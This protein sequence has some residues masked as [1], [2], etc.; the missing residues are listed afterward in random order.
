MDYLCQTADLSFIESED[1]LDLRFDTLYVSAN[2][3]I[4]TVCDISY[5]DIDNLYLAT[6]DDFV[7]NVTAYI[8]EHEEEFV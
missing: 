4:T 5:K 2:G 3:N 6:I 8:N 1:T 7:E